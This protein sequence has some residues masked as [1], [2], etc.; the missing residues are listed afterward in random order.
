MGELGFQCG[1]F[2]LHTAFRLITEAE[3]VNY[4]VVRIKATVL[5]C[6]VFLQVYKCL[7]YLFVVNDR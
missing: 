6:E 2:N 4:I 5:H 3:I 1:D 7:L